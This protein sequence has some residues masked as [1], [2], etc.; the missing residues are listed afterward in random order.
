M[1]HR[2]REHR[3]EYARKWRLSRKD[4]I[5]KREREKRRETGYKNLN[6]VRND[7]IKSEVL[8]HYGNDKLACVSCGFGDLRALSIDHKRGN[9]HRHRMKMYTGTYFYRWLRKQGYPIGYQTLC[10]NCQW[11]KRDELMEYVKPWKDG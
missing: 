7:V 4:E 5:N 10:M 1:P 8:T 11:I 3:K 2:D 6:R 9:G